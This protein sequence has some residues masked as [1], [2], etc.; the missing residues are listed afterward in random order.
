MSETAKQVGDFISLGTLM[1]VIVQLLP[2]IASVLTVIWIGL[3]I[4]ESIL[5]IR[6]AKRALRKD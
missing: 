4:Y 3:R 1:G 6:K 2:I 5:N